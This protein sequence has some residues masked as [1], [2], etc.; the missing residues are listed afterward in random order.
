MKIKRYNRKEATLGICTYLQRSCLLN[1]TY[2]RIQYTH[3]HVICHLVPLYSNAL[4]S[5]PNYPL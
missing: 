3:E 2:L 5:T 4:L 1:E